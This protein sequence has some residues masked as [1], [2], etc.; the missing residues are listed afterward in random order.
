MRAMH[1]ATASGPNSISPKH[2]A[3]LL[4]KDH[5]PMIGRD[6][7]N[8]SGRAEGPTDVLGSALGLAVIGTSVGQ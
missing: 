4:E 2:S 3:G 8:K 6:S 5:G 7:T 1:N